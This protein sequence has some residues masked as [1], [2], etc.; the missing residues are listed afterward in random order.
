M[1][2]KIKILNAGC[3]KDTYGTDFIDLYPE[4]KEVKKCNIDVEKFPY[5]SNI[6]DEV[7][8]K[9]NFEHLR[10]PL[11]FLNESYRVLKHNG[12]IKI[13]TDNAGLWGLFGEVHY[14]GLEKYGQHGKEDRHYMLFTTKHLYNWL[15]SVGFKNIEIKYSIGNGHTLKNKIIITFLTKI[16]RKFNPIIIAEARK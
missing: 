6:F 7:Y 14:G 1:V 12:K 13:T 10:N 3:G 5:K 8:S 16:S 9:N 15:E 2:M 11:N 4:R